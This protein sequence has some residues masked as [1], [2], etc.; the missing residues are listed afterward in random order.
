MGMGEKG[1]AVLRPY[2]DI[3]RFG[4]AR[5]LVLAAWRS[6]LLSC[7]GS[8]WFG[9]LVKFLAQCWGDACVFVDGLAFVVVLGMRLTIGAGDGL[10]R[11]VGFEA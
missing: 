7:A 2:K 1:P 4:G 9:L 10:R 8:E 11:F 3:A 6:G 5:H